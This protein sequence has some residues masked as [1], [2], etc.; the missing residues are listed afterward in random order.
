MKQG[1]KRIKWFDVVTTAWAIALVVA[2]IL[3]VTVPVAYARPG[4]GGGQ[5]CMGY[6]VREDKCAGAGGCA[7][8]DGDSG[9][10]CWGLCEDGT[11][12]SGCP[13]V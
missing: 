1:K 10:E 6:C 8:V 4:G 12:W 7:T 5:D 2:T 13:A 9:G 11:T 3:W